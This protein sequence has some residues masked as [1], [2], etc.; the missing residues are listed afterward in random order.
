MPLIW[1][2]RNRPLDALGFERARQLRRLNE[3]VLDRVA[4]TEQHGVLEPW[5]RVNQ[6]GLHLARQTHREPVDINLARVD[7]FGLEKDLVPLL[8]GEPDDLV[9]ERRAVARTDP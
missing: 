6:I 4:R 9:F 2:A 8:V 3:V 1:P 7:A 5:Q